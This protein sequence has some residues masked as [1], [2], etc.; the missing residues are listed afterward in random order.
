MKTSF[1][2][3]TNL[4]FAVRKDCDNE[5]IAILESNDPTVDAL[6]ITRD[7]YNDF[8]ITADCYYIGKPLNTIKRVCDA[9]EL[10]IGVKLNPNEAKTPAPKLRQA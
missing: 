1:K 5:S 8:R 2:A 6:M 4:G 10:L 3:L 9:A 7:G